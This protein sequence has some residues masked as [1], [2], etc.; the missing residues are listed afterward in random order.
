MNNNFPAGPDRKLVTGYL[1]SGNS[2]DEATTIA[3][4]NIDESA[5]T[6]AYDVYVYMANGST[7][8]RG[9][10]Y[11]LLSGTHT[12]VKYGSTGIGPAMHV[13]DAGAD[14]DNTVHGSYLRFRNLTTPSFTLRADASLTTPNGFRAT[15]AAIQIVGVPEPATAS[16]LLCATLFGP[17]VRR[18]RMR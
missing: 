9:G 5:R 11:T 13:E 17:P 14:I 1:D 2:A 7:T 6:P 10:G 8:A 16:I 3:V 15:V 12:Q 18:R 4:H